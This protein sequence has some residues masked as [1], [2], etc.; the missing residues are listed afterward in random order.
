MSRHPSG[1][2]GVA[3][4]RRG[5]VWLF[6]LLLSGLAVGAALGHGSG[7]ITRADTEGYDVSWPQ[8]YGSTATHMPVGSPSY[9]ILGLTHGTGHTVNPCLGSQLQWARTHGVRTG[10]YLVASYPDRLQRRLASGGLFGP[11]GQSLVCRLE[12]DGAAQAVE[13]VT[14]MRTVGLRAPRIWIDVE[15]RSTHRWTK[16]NRANSYVIKGIVRGL[17]HSGVRMGVYTTSYMWRA[18]VG[19]YRLH[20]P[21]W[22]PVG[23][24]GIRRAL[25]MCATTATGGVTW[26]TQYTR[27]LDMDLT[28]PVLSPVPGAHGRL[29][30]FRKTTQ[31]LLSTGAAVRA[32]QRRV[33]EPATGQYGP[34]TSLAVSR[35]QLSKGLPATGRVTPRDWRAMGAFRHHGGHGFWL[36]RIART[37]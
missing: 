25:D 28:C 4:V 11:C 37:S 34:L 12:N 9:V 36:R 20:V 21:N 17:K 29:W 5:F 19:G 8:C 16:N 6:A 27:A 23:H 32:I 1:G 22:L 26:M 13:A 3:S 24:G 14:T 7:S 31:Q 35:W 15:F 30:K 10:A 2:W 18:I 33:G